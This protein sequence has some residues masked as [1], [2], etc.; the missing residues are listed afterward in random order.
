[1]E[2]E[3]DVSDL[4]ESVDI[5]EYISQFMELE[6]GPD[7][8]YWGISCLTDHD[9]DPSFSISP[10]KQIFYD[11][12]SHK[13]GTV[14]D[15]IKY[16]NRCSFKTAVMIL[17]D[18]VKDHGLGISDDAP[19]A[20]LSCAK[21]IKRFLPKINK[22]KEAKYKNL[23]DN[24]MDVFEVDW[25][26]TKPWLDEGISLEAMKLFQVRYDPIG[27]RI[28]F[29]IRLIDGTIINVSGRTLD[30]QY[31]EHGL[32]KYTYYFPLGKFD[33]IYG[34]YENAS[35]ILEKNEIILFEGA[36]SVM[37][38]WGWGV[39]NAAALC[40]SRMN[41]YQFI[42]LLKLGVR[43]VV[44]LDSE[45]RPKDDENIARLRRYLPVEIVYNK[46]GLLEE[47]MAPVDAG[48]EVWDKLYEAREKFV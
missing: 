15:F 1:M 25:S 26:K 47:K 32:R 14:I 21:E 29:P 33:T 40:T 3:L 42:I 10:D 41:T 39:R 9:T 7:G 17:S 37:K 20:H 44:A 11:F 45:V 22:E 28:V 4:L 5:V 46:D 38:A 18:Y 35:E 31:K 24:Y 36:K 12:S 23:G 43:V 16:Y 6:T 30:P 48:K 13:G 8:E 34:F 2:H 19:K 27:N